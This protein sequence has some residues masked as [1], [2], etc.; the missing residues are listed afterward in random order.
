MVINL[1]D[2]VGVGVGVCLLRGTVKYELT[3]VPP[4]SY[5]TTHTQTD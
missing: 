1:K 3:W 4:T 2:M 5:P